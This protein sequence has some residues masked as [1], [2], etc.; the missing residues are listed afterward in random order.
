MNINKQK[1]S[2]KNYF[3]F[4]TKQKD[5]INIFKKYKI[6]LIKNVV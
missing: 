2:L 5:F 6:C 1:Y 3:R 4:S